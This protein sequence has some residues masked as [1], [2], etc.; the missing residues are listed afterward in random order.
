MHTYFVIRT[1]K[2]SHKLECCE[3]ANQ[4]LQLTK[5]IRMFHVHLSTLYPKSN[6]KVLR[7]RCYN[8][9]MFTYFIE[10]TLQHQNP[11]RL[12]FEL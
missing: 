5:F 9:T 6:L 7:N 8:F 11:N 2:H 1:N 10:I 4:K 12:N 3:I